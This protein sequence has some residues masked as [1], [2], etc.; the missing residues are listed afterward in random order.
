VRR[1]VLFAYLVLLLLSF[2]VAYVTWTREPG[3]DLSG[4]V[5]VFPCPREGLSGLELKVGD[6]TVRCFQRKSAYSNKSFW[7]IDAAGEGF[8]ASERFTEALGRFCPWMASRDLGVAGDEKK[9]EFGLAG[10]QDRLV[11][12]VGAE[13]K[14]FR[15]GTAVY[16]SQDRYVEDEESGRVYL[17]RGQDLRDFEY[18][19]SRFMERNFHGFDRE[20]VTLVRVQS[21]GR[22]AEIVPVTEGGKTKGWADAASPTESKEALRN[23]MQKYFTLRFSDYVKPGDAS[24]IMGCSAPTGAEEVFSLTFFDG[25]KEI[26]FFRLYRAAGTGEKEKALACAD[27]T[28]CVVELPWT[29]AEG[30]VKDL[31]TV[32]AGEP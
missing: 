8:K 6:R 9:Q 2:G 18:P 26:G 10:S 25:N 20:R 28:D 30:L 12:K 19:K 15:I 22:T 7:W 29:Q 14:A 24:E 5:A 31:E 21:G 4:S 13:Q 1:S 32:L 17:V 16:G 3:R 23:W 11:L 27:N